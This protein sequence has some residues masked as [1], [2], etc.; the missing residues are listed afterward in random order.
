MQQQE[1]I[2]I[3][4]L[5]THENQLCPDPEALRGAQTWIPRSSHWVISIEYRPLTMDFGLSLAFL[6]II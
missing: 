5:C 6:V 1:D 4:L 3:L 2:Q